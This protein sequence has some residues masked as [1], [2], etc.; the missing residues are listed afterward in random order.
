MLQL[1][2]KQVLSHNKISFFVISYQSAISLP[3]QPI[4]RDDRL[5]VLPL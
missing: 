2:K 4:Q 1:L 3:L 5:K